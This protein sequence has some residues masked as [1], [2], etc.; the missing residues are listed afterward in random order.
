M[1]IPNETKIRKDILCV[2]SQWVKDLREQLGV[3]GM[4]T[5]HIIID[6][7]LE[8]AVKVYVE[9]YATTDL[10]TLMPPEV[11]PAQVVIVGEK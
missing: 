2:N 6:I 11:S 3:V 5:T 4:P 1:A 9:G 7:P 10:L 8:G